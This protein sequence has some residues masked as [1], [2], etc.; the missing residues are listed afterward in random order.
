MQILKMEGLESLLLSLSLHEQTG[1]IRHV[2][3]PWGQYSTTP[4]D[5]TCFWY[6][7][8]GC[9]YATLR[10]IV[11]QEFQRYGHPATDRL[12]DAAILAFLLMP[13]QQDALTELERLLNSFADGNA[14][15]FVVIPSS[16]LIKVVGVN[17]PPENEIIG[18]FGHGPFRY[19]PLAG[20]LMDKVRYRVGRIGLKRHLGEIATLYGRITVYREPRRVK[21]IDFEKLGLR[22]SSTP[23]A[24]LMNYYFDDLAAALFE[25]FWQ[26]HLIT[27]YQ[28]VAAGANLL[29]RAS[30]EALPG[31]VWLSAFWG[32]ALPPLKGCVS[33]I[34]EVSHRRDTLAMQIHSL[35]AELGAAKS[36]LE[37]ELTDDPSR[38][39][40]RGSR[41]LHLF[42]KLM[43]R[44]RELQNRGYVEESFT[45]LVVAMESLLGERASISRTWSRRAGSLIA[46][47]QGASFSES[48]KS[49]QELY[50]LRSRYV[51]DGGAIT[52]ESLK[53]LQV[54][55]QTVFFA[56]YR[57]QI[58]CA[59]GNEASW[60]LRWVAVLDYISGCL[61][62]GFPI[63][64][65]A[66]RFS[67]VKRNLEPLSGRG[68]NRKAASKPAASRGPKKTE[69]KKR[70]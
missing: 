3:Y 47:S 10:R 34:H 70:R 18:F 65:S 21:V 53:E 58:R 60:C 69:A 5:D 13:K 32:F 57:S 7:A 68:H 30:L 2:V 8:K 31:T 38:N 14:W 52:L 43:A 27:Q 67:G 48:T 55:C 44:S 6:S 39:L 26:E 1:K 11:L 49:I 19:G 59:D 9:Q 56:A 16:S 24:A 12:A 64:P 45:L 61:E 46:L 66:T 40:S 41:S 28:S 63:D 36:R 25:E 4:G 15:Q 23:V 51:H 22:M 42:A 29:D 17:R 54:V 20:D 37:L 33:L 35:G 62:A 50:D